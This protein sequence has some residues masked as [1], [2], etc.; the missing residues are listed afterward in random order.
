M[1][2]RL[3]LAKNKKALLCSIL[4][5]NIMTCSASLTMAWFLNTSVTPVSGEG[6]INKSYFEGGDGSIDHPFQIKY[7]IQFYYFS[8]LQDMGYFN[9]EDST[10]T[11]NYQQYHF[12]LIDD[13][14][15]KDYTLPPAGSIQYPFVGSFEGNGYSISNITISNSTDT[16]TDEPLNIAG[17]ERNYQ[18][19]GVFGVVGSY[20]SMPYSFNSS[21]NYIQNLTI[22]NVTVKVTYLL[23]IS[24][25]LTSNF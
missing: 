11:G 13:I 1:K 16:Y 3:L 19:M 10:N 14:N 2:K 25:L 22:N 23:L 21:L 6:S 24:L 9:H 7:P 15:M 4:M 12:E 5:F 8:W 20:G 17:D 18:I